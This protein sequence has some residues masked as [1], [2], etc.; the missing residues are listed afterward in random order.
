MRRVHA[1]TP[2]RI[3]RGATQARGGGGISDLS[4]SRRRA[5]SGRSPPCRSK[6]SG[7]LSAL[8]DPSIRLSAYATR[9][10]ISG[11]RPSPRSKEVGRARSRARA[12][13]AP[14]PTARSRELPGATCARARPADR[15]P[16]IPE[17]GDDRF[18]NRGSTL[19]VSRRT[20]ADEAVESPTR[21]RAKA[22]FASDD[23]RLV[24]ERQRERGAA[25]R[26]LDAAQSDRGQ[27]ARTFGD[28]F[29]SRRTA[30]PVVSRAPSRSAIAF[31]SSRSAAVD[32]A[33]SA[34]AAG[35]GLSRRTCE[36]AGGRHE[37]LHTPFGSETSPQGGSA[38]LL[39]QERQRA[40]LSTLTGLDRFQGAVGGP[41]ARTQR[42]TGAHS[43]GSGPPVEAD[44]GATRRGREMERPGV[45]S[46]VERGTRRTAPRV[47]RSARFAT[48]GSV[49]RASARAA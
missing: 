19:G 5:S 46:D 17:C 23:Q 7:A 42:P 2:R 30:K 15:A 37:G 8:P 13:Q 12:R 32:F 34:L 40:R 35:A 22:R 27:A 29:S 36:E 10:R 4:E 6:A 25:T 39:H 45:V 26:I 3:R 16:S 44:G 14:R 9:Q 20:R 28:P 38:S 48:T 49:L 43:G 41:D 31:R 11:G 21:P 24:R 1:H 18:S 33:G 47:E